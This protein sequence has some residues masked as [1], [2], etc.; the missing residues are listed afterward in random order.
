MR[1]LNTVPIVVVQ[2]GGISCYDE[3]CLKEYDQDIDLV[4]CGLSVREIV[5]RV[6]AILR[7]REAGVESR[8]RYSVG[9]LL[10]DLHGHEVLINGQAVF[11]TAEL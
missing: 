3:E 10:M 5:A 8:T 11:S 7:R 4:M 6:R 9:N 2:E 1:M